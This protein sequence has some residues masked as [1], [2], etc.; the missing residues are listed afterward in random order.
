MQESGVKPS[1]A[2]LNSMLEAC[3]RSCHWQ[4]ALDLLQMLPSS[5]VSYS[6]AMMCCVQATM[7]HVALDLLQ[8]LSQVGVARTGPSYGEM[9]V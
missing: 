6:A 1:S 8:E 7:W 5:A 2:V 9:M 3:E 4:L